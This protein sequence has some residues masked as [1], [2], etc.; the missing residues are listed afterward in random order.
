MTF[1][2][3]K[4]DSDAAR[5][6]ILS[7]R[8]SP[9][10]DLTVQKQVT[11]MATD[12]GKNGEPAL[13]SYHGQFEHHTVST[14]ADLK[15]PATQIENALSNLDE[16][17]KDNLHL[18][19]KRIRQYHQKQK[20]A[21]WSFTDEYGMQLGEISRPVRCAVVYAPGGKAVYPS[22]VLMGVIPA[23]IAGVKNIILTT[24]AQGGQ[25]NPATLAA[26]HI[27]GA[28][29]VYGL[30]GA[31][32]IIG[33]ALG[34][35][36]LPAADVIVGPGNAYV[37]EAKRQMFGR[38][39]IDSFAGP[40]EV[41]IISDSSA[42]ASWVCADLMAQ[43]E[44]D[45]AAQCIFITTDAEHGNKVLQGLNTLIDQQERSDIIRQSLQQNGLFILARN[46]EDA[47]HLANSLAAEHVQIMTKDA[48]D[49]AKKIENAGSLFIGN[50]SSVPFGDY[51]AGPNHTLPTAGAARFSSP[52]S[53]RH[54]LKQ[55]SVTMVS[56]KAAQHL[57]APVA[58][59]AQS[60]GLFAHAQ[61]VKKRHEQ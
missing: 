41:L 26:A 40:S 50:Y 44:H 5:Q 11:A 49:L 12:I 10:T 60:E 4:L 20:M 46:T 25:I 58:A 13:L 23:V 42:P 55:T 54:F 35:G 24:P 45:E 7:A 53:V 48:A 8:S 29:Q 28:H 47:C 2:L 61:A 33:F 39:G 57:A 59:L 37:A 21:D 43:A 22:S 14:L 32:A 3:I 36:T 9:T 38:V 15:I 31:Q 6:R 16:S 18:A 56:Q 51:L 27:A 30:G 34:T 52:L 1:Q 19:A 17:L